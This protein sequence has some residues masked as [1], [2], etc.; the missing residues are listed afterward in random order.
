MQCKVRLSSVLALALM[1]GV[2]VAMRADTVFS[3]FGPGQSF[4]P[5]GYVDIGD[6]GSGDQ[7]VTY[8]FVP[9]ETVLLSSVDMGL[10]QDGPESPLNVSISF[11]TNG[12]PGNVIDPLTQVGTFGN[13][14]V[15]SFICGSGSAVCPVLQA[16]DTYWLVAQQSDA[17]ALSYWFFSPSDTGPGYY[18][19][20]G[21]AT[22]PWTLGTLSPYIG[23]FDVNG[24]SSTTPP[25]P[26]P[27]SL[28]LLGS[29]MVGLLV[30]SRRRF[31]RS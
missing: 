12:M 17:S 1:L 28:L 6:G 3:S 13:A 5:K 14:G 22:G 30:A 16:G 25:V 20:T 26:E 4:Q 8:S 15:V 7:V 9:S 11:D 19:E 21:S 18:D 2:S 29:G 31:A 24:S 27:A 23:A 10:A